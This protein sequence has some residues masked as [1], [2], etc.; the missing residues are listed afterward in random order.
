MLLFCYVFFRKGEHFAS[1]L[2][3]PSPV[4]SCTNS[5]L[6]FFLRCCLLLFCGEDTVRIAGAEPRRATKVVQSP[7]WGKVK[8]ALRYHMGICSALLLAFFRRLRAQWLRRG[9]DRLS[10]KKEAV[11]KHTRQHFSAVPNFLHHHARN[12]SVQ[13]GCHSCLPAWPAGYTG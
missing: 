2:F 7:F 13:S 6:S 8:V 9:I 3:S 4:S 11:S 1:P 5:L 10:K 12:A